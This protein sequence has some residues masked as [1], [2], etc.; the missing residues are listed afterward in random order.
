MIYKKLLEKRQQKN[1]VKNGEVDLAY[2]MIVRPDYPSY[3]N[4]VKRGATTL[5]EGFYPEN[6]RVL[7]LNHH[8]WGD[9]SAWLYTYLAGIRIN[10][11][12]KDVI[13]LDIMPLFPKKLDSVSAYHD[14]PVGRISVSW[15]RTSEE[16]II[17]KIEAA[18]KLHGKIVLT[19]GFT[20]L[21]G[22]KEK[23]LASGNFHL[24]AN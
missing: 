5:W 2:N 18:E 3:G 4:L 11:T 16:S 7:S 12:G 6:G 20:F 21:D 9:V 1:Q 8:F 10:P 13:N 17:L 15:E 14:T 23:T 24:S 19:E 22:S